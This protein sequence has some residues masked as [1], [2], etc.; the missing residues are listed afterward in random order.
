MTF[1]R[2][3]LLLDKAQHAELEKLARESGRSMSDLVR[4]I[5][6]GY[7][8]QASEEESFRRSLGALDSLAELRHQIE[9]AHGPLPRSFLDELREDRDSEIATRAGKSTTRVGEPTP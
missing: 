6:A 2:A 1:Y 3:Q 9:S 8:T 5:V 7:L 4:E